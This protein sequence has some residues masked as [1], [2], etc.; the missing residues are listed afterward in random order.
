M[1]VKED[2][3]QQWQEAMAGAQTGTSS[4]TPLRQ[5]TTAAPAAADHSHTAEP[6]A[7]ANQRYNRLMKPVTDN[8]CHR[9]PHIMHRRSAVVV[10]ACWAAHLPLLPVAMH[11]GQGPPAAAEAAPKWPGKVSIPHKHAAIINI[12]T[13]CCCCCRFRGAAVAAITPGRLL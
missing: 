4:S 12:N 1:S 9:V 5:G 6:A 8:A 7:V 10:K 13:C 2:D 3:K 11:Q